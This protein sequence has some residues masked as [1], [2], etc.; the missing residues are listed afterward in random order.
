MDYQ[1]SKDTERALELAATND[2]DTPMYLSG[3]PVINVRGPARYAMWEDAAGIHLQRIETVFNFKRVP[4]PAEMTVADLKALVEEDAKRY[5]AMTRAEK[6]QDDA[7]KHRDAKREG[8]L[9]DEEGNEVEDAL[10]EKTDDEAEDVDLD[11]QKTGAFEDAI[12]GDGIE[13]VLAEPEPD[14]DSGAEEEEDEQETMVRD[15]VEAAGLTGKRKGRRTTPEE[16]ASLQAL[17]TS[18]EDVV[19]LDGIPKSEF[20]TFIEQNWPEAMVSGTP[21]GQLYQR[22]IMK[23]T[24]VVDGLVKL[25]K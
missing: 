2:T 7:L 4:P 22:C 15:A 6:K 13:D 14:S 12:D 5:K 8:D 18:I 19:G 17:G 11:A 20:Q 3:Q 10:I 25:K 24:R 21:R 1:R 9:E 23:L 16:Q